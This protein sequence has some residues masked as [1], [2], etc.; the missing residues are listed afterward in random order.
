VKFLDDRRAQGALDST[1]L[2]VVS[3][4]GSPPPNH[5][6]RRLTA[7]LVGD[8]R[9]A[10]GKVVDANGRTLG[11]FLRAVAGRFGAAATFGGDRTID[12]I[13]SP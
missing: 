2:L 5:D 13:F 4:C 3:E 12:G 11:D 1:L 6:P 8:A 10:G 9:L 7:V